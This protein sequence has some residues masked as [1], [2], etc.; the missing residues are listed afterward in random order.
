MSSLPMSIDR[1]LADDALNLANHRVEWRALA[2]VKLRQTLGI[3]GNL[4]ALVFQIL[5]QCAQHDP[6]SRAV[7]N[8][9]RAEGPVG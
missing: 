1:V 5:P 9:A 2:S 7:E 6:G 4:R 8:A 3:P